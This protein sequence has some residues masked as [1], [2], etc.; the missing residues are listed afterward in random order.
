MV[1]FLLSEWGIIVRLSALHD[2]FPWHCLHCSLCPP[3][4]NR[5]KFF[6]EIFEL[7]GRSLLF[8]SNFK[9]EPNTLEIVNTCDVYW[10]CLSSMHII[11]DH[12]LG[13]EVLGKSFSVLD[14]NVFTLE[15]APVKHHQLSHVLQVVWDLRSQYCWHSS[16][17][18]KGLSF[19]LWDVKGLPFP[20]KCQK[21]TPYLCD[22]DKNISRRYQVS[23]GGQNLPHPWLGSLELVKLVT[24]LPSGRAMILVSPLSP[25]LNI[26]P[27][28]LPA[29]LHCPVLSLSSHFGQKLLS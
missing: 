3:E 25:E 27:L 15:N 28:V 9:K 4:G 23:P 29:G 6:C 10:Y 21:Y 7:R 24:G 8:K 26:L 18:E 14:S 22:S 11:T 5:L 16:S 20:I 13:F 17:F 1:V 2:L 12:F 19:A